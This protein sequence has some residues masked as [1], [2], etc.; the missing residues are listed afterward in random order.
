MFKEKYPLKVSSVIIAPVAQ[1]FYFD[2]T[3]G[4]PF[5]TLKGMYC[6]SKYCNIPKTSVRATLSRMCKEGEIES[7]SDENGVMRY[8]MSN[9]MIL[10]SEQ[11]SHFGRSDGFTLAVF[12]FKKE[13]D[14]ERYR[15]REILNSFGFK[16][17]AQNVYLNIRVDSEQIRKEIAKWEL[18]NNVYLFDCDNIKDHSMVDRISELWELSH[19][20]NRLNEF[21][22][23]LKTYF[24]FDNKSEEEIYQRYSYGYSVY[25]V[26]FYEKLPALPSNFFEQDNGLKKVMDLME[27]TLLQYADKICSY[28]KVINN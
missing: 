13:N 11:A 14:K 12:N 24:N 19:W 6:L 22:Q 8:R 3:M 28:Y 27:T 26:Y 17:L 18:Q 7:F 15:V 1:K 25:F 23:D 21:Y 10:I 4:L 20:N 9:M 16:K 2:N 5:P